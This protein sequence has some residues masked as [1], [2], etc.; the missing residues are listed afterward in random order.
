MKDLLYKEFKLALHP[1]VFFFPLFVAMLLIPSYPYYFAFAYNCMSVFMMFQ[2]ARENKDILY[3]MMLP[4]RKRDAVKARLTVVLIIELFQIALSIPVAIL[5]TRINP[6]GNLAGIE[7]NV[8]LY[9]LVLIMYAMFNFMYFTIFYKT[10]YGAGKA[11]LFSGIAVLL[12]IGIAE[13]IVHFPVV[14]PY[15]D[16]I[17]RAA[18]IKQLPLL[19]AGAVLFILSAVFTYKRSVK[20]F[21]MVDL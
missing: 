7:A 5:S 11:F 2:M 10:A 20:L 1:T 16:T 13:V 14:G 18:Q 8:A 21:E 12:F 19:G 6:T 4:V 15:L 17:E 3:T 9:G